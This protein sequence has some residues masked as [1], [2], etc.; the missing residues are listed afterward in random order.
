MVDRNNTDDIK[1]KKL[2]KRL[3]IIL[4]F[5]FLAVICF[6]GV[7][8]V[9]TDFD[10]LHKAFGQRKKV[11]AFLEDQ[12]NYTQWDFLEARVKSLDNYLSGNVYMSD[13]LGVLNSTLQYAMGKRMITTGGA[14]MLTLN[15][16]HLYDLQDY[17]SMDEAAHN[18]E[19][20]KQNCAD[21]PFLF[22]YEHPT[23]YD[24][25]QQ[26]PAGY[27]ALD[28]SREIADEIVEKTRALGIDTIDSREV[29]TASNTPLEE[30]LMYTD[31]H[32]STKAALILARELLPELS[33][34]TG[35]TLNET[36]LADDQLNTQTFEKLFLGKYGQRAG[37]NNIAP[38]DITI[39]W[40]KYETNI[41]RY[42]YYL[43]DEY[44]LTGSFY[45]SVIRWKYL[46][47]D[48][49][50]SWNIKAYFDY[51][52][53]ENYDLFE[54][55]DGADLTVLLLK[56]SYSAP[57][58]SFLSLAVKNVVSVDLR[59]SEQP[60]E[61]WVEEYKPD[62]VIVAYSMQML[63]DDDYEFQ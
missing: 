9:A 51:G 34:M 21:T 3:D 39:Y 54:N 24:Y 4:T 2:Q 7:M 48:E 15:T 10:G 49:G 37:V 47:P 22:L 25:E 60:L 62:A 16:G 1:T 28:Y 41:H 5:F 52:L 32:W 50:K 61:T 6:M 56:D 36:L 45:D 14:S 29:L 12:E 27:E 18:I 43:G 23:I 26:M 35:T 20:M 42:T 31:Q 55:P 30:Y 63:R 13:E 44:D 17:V 19:Q 58:A 59:R 11:K 40:P 8:T 38:D 46:E 33:E 57:I 53:T